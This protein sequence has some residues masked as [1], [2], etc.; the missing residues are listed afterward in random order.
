MLAGSGELFETDNRTSGIFLCRFRDGT[1]GTPTPT[2]A[3]ARPHIGKQAACQIHDRR[4][5]ECQSHD[6]LPI[7]SEHDYNR[8]P[9]W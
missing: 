3:L 9:I 6:V 7:E 4:G 2:A 1:G 5:H 8:I